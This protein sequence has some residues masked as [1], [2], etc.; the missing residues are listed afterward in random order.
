MSEQVTQKLY[1]VFHG[2][3][4]LVED[5]DGFHAILIEMTGHTVA[6]GHWLTEVPLQK[7]GGAVLSLD[8]VSAGSARIDPELNLVVNLRELDMDKVSG[9]PGCYARIDMPKPEKSYSYFTADGEGRLTGTQQPNSKKYSA[10][11]VFEYS[12]PGGT[13]DRVGISQGDTAIWKNEGY[14]ITRGGTKTSVLHIYNEPAG[15][16]SDKHAAD[17]FLKGSALF[18]VDVGLAGGSPLPF[19]CEWQPSQSDLPPGLLLQELAPLCNRDRSVFHILDSARRGVPVSEG[20]PVLAG[21]FCS[22]I[23]IVIGLLHQHYWPHP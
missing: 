9:N 13:F 6:V 10:V 22:A 5:K 2:L 16:E 11:Q 20:T 21:V 3:I 18:G 8:G 15:E 14:T 17:E 7:S 12:V 1:V 4:P 19:P 23:F